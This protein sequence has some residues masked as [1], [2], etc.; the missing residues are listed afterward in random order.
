MK[1]LKTFESLENPEYWTIPI[2]QP[3]LKLAFKKIG[4]SPNEIKKWYDMTENPKSSLYALK[5]VLI[6]RNN[7]G[8]SWSG[9]NATDDTGVK[10]INNPNYK[11]MGRIFINDYEAAAYKYNI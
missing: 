7:Y 8:W 5:E 10:Y 9:I 11:H 1:H 6:F 4:M 2:N 3:Y